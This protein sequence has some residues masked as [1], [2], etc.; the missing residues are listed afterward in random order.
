[1]TEKFIHFSILLLL[2]SHEVVLINSSDVISTRRCPSKCTITGLNRN[3]FHRLEQ[4]CP[5]SES[6]VKCSTSL[7]LI[8]NGTL[9]VSFDGDSSAQAINESL[10]PSLFHK[11]FYHHTQVTFYANVSETQ[12]NVRNACFDQDDCSRMFARKIAN[13]LLGYHY[14]QLEESIKPIIYDPIPNTEIQFF[15]P[16]LQCAIDSMSTAIPCNTTCYVL[17]SSIQEQRLCWLGSLV[18]LHVYTENPLPVPMNTT[19]TFGYNYPTFSRNFGRSHVDDTV[20]NTPLLRISQMY[21]T[22]KPINLPGG[23]LS[24]DQNE[25][26]ATKILGNPYYIKLSSKQTDGQFTMMEGIVLPG[27]GPAMHVHHFENEAFYVL[28]GEI[29]FII[30]NRTVLASKGTCVYAP[31]GVV[32]TFRNINGTNARPARLQFWFSPAGIENYFEQVSR[33][34]NQKPPN[35]D[36]AIQIA[37]EWGID[38]IGPPNWSIGS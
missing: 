20:T 15:T 7:W 14:V 5:N 30:N 38:I 21:P 37:K 13:Q 35:F 22:M 17:S 36:L 2:L 27:E 32:H 4:D 23:A 10:T 1:M 18:S 11:F 25:G 19:I 31:R 9:I 24:L 26:E 34:L 16:N 12:V 28:E 29:Q 8:A 6:F 3:S 33:V